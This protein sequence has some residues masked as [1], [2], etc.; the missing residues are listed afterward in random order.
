MDLG[1]GSLF[2]LPAPVRVEAE[3][4]APAPI[5]PSD[6]LLAG[7]RDD[8]ATIDQREIAKI[9]KIAEWADLHVVDDESAAA[10]IT[11][12]GLD[13][14]LPVAGPGAPLISDF[15]VMQLATLLGRTLDSG[16]FYVGQVVELRHRLTR[17]WTRVLVG[18]VPVWKA[19]R[20][21]DLTRSLPADAAAFVDA[22]MAPFAHSMSWAQLDRLLDAALVRFDPEA[23]EEKRKQA[24]E[25]RG[26]DLGLDR[27]DSNGIAYGSTALDVEDAL[28]L[29]NAIARRSKHLGELGSEDSLD[30]RRAKALGE[31]AREDLTL[32]LQVVD[33]ETGEI[34]R[35]IRGQKL[36]IVYHLSDDAVL[37]RCGTT[38]TPI[39]PA[40]LQEVL[41]APGTK[42]IV[43]PVVDLAGHRPVD[44]YEVP[45]RLRFQVTTRDHHCG[46]PYCG[47]PAESCDLDHVEPHGDGGVTCPCNLA[48]ACR[49]H[50]RLKTAGLAHC[51]VLHPGTYL[52]TL[53]TGTYLVDPT[54][55]YQLASALPEASVEP[56]VAY[57]G[58]PPEH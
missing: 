18:R 31:I 56:G 30:V 49:G 9:K 14:G 51:R 32:D 54:G 57:D 10:T 6:A 36:E 13:T 41:A 38:R 25:Q 24:A 40:H 37:A 46:Y 23:A 20:I 22:H 17:T 55:T 34:T 47:R 7:I 2:D 8:Q 15:A 4:P 11:E 27:V 1:T 58:D 53:P 35:T 28:D 16:R 52:W 29:E 42:V 43:R 45:D 33:P 26:V 3:Q 48:P 50:H 21:A 5:S 19:L 44:S 39:L 12:R